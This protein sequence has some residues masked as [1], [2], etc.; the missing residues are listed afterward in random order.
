MSLFGPNIKKMLRENDIEGLKNVVIQT[1]NTKDRNS[2]IHALMELNQFDILISLMS[3]PVLMVILVSILARGGEK[4]I[5]PLLNGLESKEKFV[6]GGAA[7][8]LSVMRTEQAVDPIIAK[9]KDPQC[10]AR[11]AMIV[12]LGKIRGDKAIIALTE[13]TQDK[14]PEIKQSATSAILNP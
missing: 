1:K 7:T 11:I 2:T 10:N 3:D 6:Q 12:A 9:A 14:N 4:V 5:K 8:A 13:L